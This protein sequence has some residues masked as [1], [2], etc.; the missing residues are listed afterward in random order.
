[1]PRYCQHTDC[2]MPATYGKYCIFHQEGKKIKET[3]Y[4]APVSPKKL[5][6]HKEYLKLRKAFLKD[7]PKCVVCDKK[8]DDVH[9]RLKR[10]G[11]AKNSVETWV[12]LCRDCHT[13]CH[14]DNDFATQ[15]DL[16]ADQEEKTHFFKKYGKQL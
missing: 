6:A 2:N 3:K 4:I 8:S 15:Y 10:S 5:E 9:H 14:S 12:A 11:A 16:M 1:M 13:K 7:N